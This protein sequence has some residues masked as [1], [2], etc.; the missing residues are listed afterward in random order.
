[1]HNNIHKLRARQ[2]INARSHAQWIL[3][4]IEA[5]GRSACQRRK[6]EDDQ[7][8]ADAKDQAKCEH[9]FSDGP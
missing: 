7:R 5:E 6:R 8:R 3:R 2:K 1:M 4:Q 9:L